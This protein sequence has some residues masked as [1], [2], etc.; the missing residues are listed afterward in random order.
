[1]PEGTGDWPDWPGVVMDDT[2]GISTD[3]DDEDEEE[4]E[5]D[6]ALVDCATK[7]VAEGDA[8]TDDV[9]VCEVVAPPG[10]GAGVL[11]GVNDDVGCGDCKNCEETAESLEEDVGVVSVSTVD[12]EPFGSPEEDGAEELEFGSPE[13]DVSG[14]GATGGACEAFGSGLG[15]ACVLCDPPPLD[16]R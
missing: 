4:N 13:E 12:D 6:T 11:L 10:E 9:G 15:G 1:M 16:P 5:S 7:F 3:E 14:V 8:L 2:V